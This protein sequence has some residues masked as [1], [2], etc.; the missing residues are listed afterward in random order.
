MA[1]YEVRPLT[2][3]VSATVTVPGSKS[4]TNRA[5]L[6]AALAAG[7]SHLGGALFSD[8]TRVMLDSLARL[9]FAA[10]A[11]EQAATIEVAGAGGTIPASEADLN[12]GNAGTAAR[13]LTAFLTLG[14]G[15]YLLDGSS[16]MR[17]RPIGELLDALRALGADVEAVRGNGCPPVRVRAAGLEGGEAVVDASRSGQFLS[18]LL[19]IGAYTRRGVR[20]TLAGHLASPPYIDMTLR[21]MEE[22]GVQAF[23]QADLP[24]H[25]RGVEAH[26]ETDAVAGASYIVPGGQRYV[27]RAY[28]VPPDASGASYFLAAAA[29]TGGTVRVRHLALAQEQGDLGFVGVLE[30]MGCSVAQEGD[31]IILTGPQTLHG[32]DLDMNGISDMS[33]TLA[34]IA[35][36]ASGPVMIRNVAHI[37]HQETDRVAAM[38]AELRRLGAGVEERPDGLSISPSSL[39][40]ALVHTYDDHRMA[41]AFAI[42][43][44]RVAGVAIENPACVAKTFPDYFARLEAATG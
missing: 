33:I 28:D 35:P 21:M 23:R 36:F 41:M 34:A 9:G 44:L 1:V 10:H 29:I 25:Q 11:D 42:T 32:I 14:T 24:A 27:A 15:V 19:M 30:R 17:E 13:F 43:G 31:D 8:D 16:R 3:P 12:V 39:H 20:L 7:T 26:T 18:A 40:G 2:R 37:R 6:L 4:Q 38:A 5:L 22:W